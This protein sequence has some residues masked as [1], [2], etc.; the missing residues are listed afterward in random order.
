MK[1]DR[2]GI[3]QTG[4]L[5]GVNTWMIEIGPRPEVNSS[6]PLRVVIQQLLLVTANLEEI[7]TK[8]L[9]TY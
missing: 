5:C 2:I 3:T 6:S 7:Q 4:N 1:L 9:E 8:G